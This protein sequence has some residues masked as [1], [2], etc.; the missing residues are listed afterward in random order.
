MS[1]LA[2]DAIT[3]ATGTAAI[4]I[5]SAGRITM[6]NRPAFFAGKSGGNSTLTLGTFPLDQTLYNVGNHYNTS[7]Y[8]FTAPIA[9]L[10]HFHAQLYYN[11]GA[12]NF[13]AHFR[14]NG[15]DRIMTAGTNATA[16]DES[17]NIS[18]NT[19]LAVGD[20]IELYSD[21]NTSRT[22]YYFL[23]GTPHGPHTYFEGYLIG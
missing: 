9:G 19:Q 6:P 13:R 18:I 15:G 17:L 23:G 12:G 2:V 8:R 1:T 16:N 14:K 21:Q 7:T 4:N 22:L 10:Y 20:Y 5:D 3:N 11:S